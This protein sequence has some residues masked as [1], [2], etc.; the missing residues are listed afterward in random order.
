MKSNPN[1]TQAVDKF[2]SWH[3]KHPFKLIYATTQGKPTSKPKGQNTIKPGRKTIAWK[4]ARAKLKDKFE[5][6]GITYCELNYPG[7][8]VNNFLGF[9]HAKK[10]RYLK[11]DELEEVILVCVNCHTK[12]EY[13]P[14]MEKEVK[15]VILGREVD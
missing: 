5:D 14:E 1:T 9:A 12:L 10:R 15:R 6:M 2:T 7:C 4:L 8:L 13:S 3:L 11:E